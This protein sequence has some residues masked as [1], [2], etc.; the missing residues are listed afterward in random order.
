MNRILTIQWIVASRWIRIHTAPK[1]YTI[2]G[3]YCPRATSHPF[4]GSDC[5]IWNKCNRHFK[6]DLIEKS[7][8]FSF[9]GT[10][11]YKCFSLLS[12]VDGTYYPR[13][14]QSD[15]WGKSLA[16]SSACAIFSVPANFCSSSVCTHFVLVLGLSTF[17]E[18]WESEAAGQGQT[19]DFLRKML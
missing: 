16:I 1:L 14:A 8:H 10:R 15:S 18:V 7:R 9:S 19:S 3:G 6:S 4:P 12:L 11:L 17:P 5:T 13:F 2:C